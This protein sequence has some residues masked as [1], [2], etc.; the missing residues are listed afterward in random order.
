MSTYRTPRFLGYILS[1]ESYSVIKYLRVLRH[2]EYYTNNR[3]W[4]NII[5]YIYYF[6]R[7]RRLVKTLGIRIRPNIVG[8]GLYIP[9]Y[10]GGV[11][12]NCTSLGDFCTV[13]SG[14]IIGGKTGQTSLPIIGDYVEVTIGSKIIGNVTIGSNVIIAPNS[15]VVKDVPNNTIVSG[16][17]AKII[18]EDIPQ[19]KI[20]IINQLNF[21]ELIA[22][23]LRK[24]LYR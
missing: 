24:I 22:I 12:V 16:V 18:K 6:L 13:S 9:H 14:C 10:Y 1:D 19:C 17:P 2:L 3:K 5:S 21:K 20:R 8:K 7:H 15:V 11:I 23:F 4:Y